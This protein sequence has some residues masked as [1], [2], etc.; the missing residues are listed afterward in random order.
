MQNLDKN[1]YRELTAIDLK[2]DMDLASDYKVDGVVLFGGSLTEPM[3]KMF[4]EQLEKEY[5]Q[6]QYGQPIMPDGLFSK[7]DV[8]EIAGKRIWFDVVYGGAYMSELL[9][10][11]ALFGSQINLLVGM[12]GGLQK[13]VATN[14]VIVPI[15][16]YGN[17]STTRM[18]ALKDELNH[19]SDQN[20]SQK[21]KS[22]IDYAP[23]HVGELTTCQAMLGES[24]E[25]IQKWENDGFIGVEMESSTLFAVSNHFN[26]KAAAILQV[27]DN[28]AH[29]VS[30]LS[31][32]YK[33]M[34]EQRYE[35]RRKNMSL[36]IKLVIEN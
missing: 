22:L 29:N 6:A 31:A 8:I 17:E 1:M 15:S 9:H 27:A 19:K 16:T 12:C 18:Y 30:V 21:I 20:L 26:I 10:I 28:L 33:L 23:V 32:E 25:D 5:P 2:Q 34:K 14:D 24:I 36:A 13:S 4:K 3:R 11:A 7:I 35:I